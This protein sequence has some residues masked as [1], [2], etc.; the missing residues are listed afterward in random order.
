MTLRADARTWLVGA[1]GLIVGLSVVLRVLAP[2]GMDPAAF[3]GFDRSEAPSQISYPAEVLGRPVPARPLAHDGKYFFAQANDPWYLHP[4]QH[5]VVLDAPVYRAQRMLFPAI[6]GGFG[7]FPAGLILWSMLLTNVFALGLGALFASRLAVASGLSPWLG[8]WVPL[9]VG[10]LLDVD[11]GTAGALAYMFSLAALL[12]LNKERRWLSGL[13]FASAAL[14][15]ETMVLFALGV[16]ALRWIQRRDVAWRSLVPSVVAMGVWNVYIRV[17]LSDVP[18]TGPVAH[19][20]RGPFVGLVEAIASWSIRP[21][22]LLLNLTILGIVVVFVPLA[23]RSRLAI[24][25][26]ALP[27]AGLALFLSEAVWRYAFDF[28]RAIAPIFTAIPFLVASSRTRR[29]TTRA[30]QRL[31]LGPSWKGPDPSDVVEAG[32][33]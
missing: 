33:S 28:P 8:L 4:E 29:C 21:Q 19:N 12:A 25:W 3:V 9:N 27:F 13:L 14:T 15:R 7:V 22:D 31:Q 32:G 23:F 1:V 10:L 24:V 20:L 30:P 16:I 5:A 18:G 2:Y 6:A 11:L 26:G 17:Q